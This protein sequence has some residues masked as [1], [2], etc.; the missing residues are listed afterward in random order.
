[1]PKTPLSTDVRVG[2]RLRLRRKQ[3]G[4]SQQKLADQL[5][6]TFQQVQK[7]ERGIN[8]VGASRLQ[9]I[10]NAL[11][12][13]IGYFFDDVELLPV[14]GAGEFPALH[15]LRER[16]ELELLSAFSR[17]TDPGVKRAVV[18]LALSLA[19]VVETSKREKR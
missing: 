5:G 6:I 18:N 8:R 3:L 14:D 19:R 15:V 13:P 2:E 11:E 1:M 16:E 7:Y 9:A 4:L 10:A 12:V 17:I